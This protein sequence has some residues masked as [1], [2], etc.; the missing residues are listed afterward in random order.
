MRILSRTIRLIGHSRADVWGPWL[1]A[2]MR[3]ASDAAASGSPIVL[4]EPHEWYEQMAAQ[5]FGPSLRWRKGPALPDAQGARPRQA[6]TVLHG[7]PG[8]PTLLQW[9]GH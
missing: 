4:V 5:S 1:M 3:D 8:Q 6:A 2:M 7:Q 9:L